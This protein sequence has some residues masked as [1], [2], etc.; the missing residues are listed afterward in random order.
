MMKDRSGEA[1]AVHY[2]ELA[3]DSTQRPWFQTFVDGRGYVDFGEKHG[4]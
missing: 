3:G 4:L 1:H 2:L